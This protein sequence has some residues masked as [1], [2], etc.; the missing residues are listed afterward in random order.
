[1]VTYSERY[2]MV[3]AQL[4]ASRTT[5]QK[6]LFPYWMGSIEAHHYSA[7]CTWR[8]LLELPRWRP[9]GMKP[10]GYSCPSGPMSS[11]LLG[12]ARCRAAVSGRF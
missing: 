7:G 8:F 3:R 4:G 5:R 1:M 10:K 2:L 6:L 11:Q 12:G 9:F